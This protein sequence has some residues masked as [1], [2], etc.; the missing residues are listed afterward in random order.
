MAASKP[1]ALPGECPV[2]HADDIDWQGSEVDGNYIY[3]KAACNKCG[4]RFNEIYELTFIEME[5]IE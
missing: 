1:N 5:V 3:Y 4:C 2:C